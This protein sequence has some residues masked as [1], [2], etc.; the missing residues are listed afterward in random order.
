MKRKRRTSEEVRRSQVAYHEAGHV[1]A[2]LALG[3][4]WAEGATIEP[5]ECTREHAR[6][7]VWFD[8]ITTASITADLPFS[9]LDRW[10][11]SAD[12]ACKVLLA[13][14]I[15]QRRAE[16]HSCIF[17]ATGD[18]RACD[19]ELAPFCRT[20]EQRRAEYA[21]LERETSRLLREPSVWAAVEYVAEALLRAGT[22]MGE[23]MFM[24]NAE[25]LAILRGEG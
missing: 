2:S 25:A 15:A 7:E 19:A 11:P 16:R 6:G 24:V 14:F 22:L 23:E 12:R 8:G 4:P 9:E 17:D 1:V 10:R 21:R 18:Y 13:G 20:K 3:G 5:S